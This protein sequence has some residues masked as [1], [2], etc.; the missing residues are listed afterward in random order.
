MAKMERKSFDHPEE[1]RSIEK[2][3][4][5][6]VK[7]GEVTAMRVRFEPGW[8]WSE[9]VKP[10]VGTPSCQVGHLM[11]VVSGRMGVRMDDGSEVEF[12][13]GDVG[14]SV[15]GDPSCPVPGRPCLGALDDYLIERARI[16]AREE[17]RPLQP[18]LTCPER[19]RIALGA[20][21]RCYRCRSHHDTERDHVKGSGSGPA[22]LDDD[23]NLNRIAMQGERVLPGILRDDLC[24]GCR[25]GFALRLG[26]FLGRLE[27][28]P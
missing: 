28:D 6:V 10:V 19:N 21:V 9:C 17:G 4:I 1:T 13:P 12:R 14:V 16:K 3:K 26:I 18:C 27:V 2:G 5:E 8:R 15:R 23:A 11:H 25:S 24:S 20:A 7:L 22:V